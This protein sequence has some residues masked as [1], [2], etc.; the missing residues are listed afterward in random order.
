MFILIKFSLILNRDLEE[1]HKADLDE[2]LTACKEE[3]ETIKGDIERNYLSEI[4]RIRLEHEEHIKDLARD[5][6]NAHE[7]ELQ[8]LSRSH[9]EELSKLQTVHEDIL[10]NLQRSWLDEQL[11]QLRSEMSLSETARLTALKMQLE[12]SHAME[13]QALK[14]SLLETS[15]TDTTKVT[16]SVTVRLLC[17]ALKT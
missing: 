6:Q 17:R 10:S 15:R 9:S 14:L 4:K 5:L 7:R 16:V 2:R 3:M 1:Q 12:E 8:N 13:L 11:E